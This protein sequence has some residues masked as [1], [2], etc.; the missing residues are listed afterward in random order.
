M[1]KLNWEVKLGIFL[2]AVTCTI[3]SA[4]FIILQNPQDTVN[5]I[6]NSM[7]FLPINVL[8]VTIVLN[9]LLAIRSK[10]EKFEK[11]NMVIG[12]FFSEAGN[13]L[14]KDISQ[15]DPNL[16]NIKNELIISNEWNDEDFEKV[17]KKLSSHDYDV[18]IDKIE[19]E[20]LNGFLFSKR[21]FLLR[22]LENPVLL[23][24]ESFTELLRAIFHLAEELKC[25][26]DLSCLP[27]SDYMHLQ[28][29]IKRVYG[30]LIFQW[31][32]YMKHL[33]KHYPY[34]FSLE[35]RTNPFDLNS[36]PVV[37]K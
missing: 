7:G 33:N 15:N 17:R 22:L 14:I 37:E 16:E 25:R 5:Y 29:D 26:D 2:I 31:L 9:K 30:T 19:I 3:Y 4:K 1:S 6:F 34:L 11:L 36:S 28:G 35:M 21:E 24:H 20:A 27:K 32:D 13:H 8:L 23:E 12:T 10:R 18:N